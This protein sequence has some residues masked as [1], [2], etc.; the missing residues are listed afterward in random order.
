VVR[1][2]KTLI[3]MQPSQ[4]WL[5]GDD[6][7]IEREDKRGLAKL[8]DLNELDAPERVELALNKTERRELL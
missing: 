3:S 2:L 7:E 8:P 5:H 1:L 6:E 4:F